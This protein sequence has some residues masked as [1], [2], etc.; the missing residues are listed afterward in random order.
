MTGP[1]AVTKVVVRNLP[2][3]I[4]EEVVTQALPT[5]PGDSIVYKRFIRD[6]SKSRLILAVSSDDDA[7]Q[8][9][10]HLHGATFV[11][12]RGLR[13]TA[14]VELSLSQRVPKASVI[15]AKGG[16]PKNRPDP[17]ESTIASDSDFLS[18]CQRID[19]ED[20]YVR[21]SAEKQL[22]PDDS[23]SS[24]T[25]S[26]AVLKTPLMEHVEK[27]NKQRKGG[28]PGRRAAP[29]SAGSDVGI[30]EWARSQLEHQKLLH[31]NAA[32]QS[33]ARF[34]SSS[35]APRSS[36]SAASAESSSS[37]ASRKKGDHT[38]QQDSQSLPKGKG[39]QHQPEQ[40]QSKKQQPQADS[41]QYKRSD[42]AQQLSSSTNKG[43]KK[44]KERGAGSET[45]Q[46]PK[47]QQPAADAKVVT[48]QT[49]KATK[50]Q[51]YRP[52]K[53]ACEEGDASLASPRPNNQ[54]QKRRPMHHDDVSSAASYTNDSSQGDR[55]DSNGISA[56]A[57]VVEKKITP[58]GTVKGD[59]T[60]DGRRGKGKGSGGRNRGSKHA[61]WV[62][63]DNT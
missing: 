52:V 41:Q 44:S 28:V 33:S 36:R 49:E 54:Q 42:K 39:K 50:Q 1:G 29:K 61:Q 2:Q 14:Y 20:Q 7:H 10:A 5:L 11:S 56:G 21:P 63:K 37:S 15:Y 16:S 24:S 38:S 3:A 22:S 40:G 12:A 30:N 60:S 9:V 18:F 46:K 17:E 35:T 27:V 23:L 51:Q 58:G 6:K 45:T 26:S 55:C 48:M 53:A 13:H 34:S 31:E 19:D 32:P 62:P 43:S 4:P 47:E 8:L 25:T 57:V 59:G